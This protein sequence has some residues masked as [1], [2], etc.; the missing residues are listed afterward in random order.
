MSKSFALTILLLFTS[1]AWAEKIYKWVDEN[2]QIHYSAQKPPNQA[3]ETVKIRKGPKLP[4]PA[5][6]APEAADQVPSVEEQLAAQDAQDAADE[7]AAREQLAE[8]DRINRRKQC[9]LARQNL[10][11]LNATVRVTR[12]NA[13]GEIVRMTDDERV[14]AMKTAQQAIRRYCQ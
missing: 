11:A 9:D 12:K 10:A 6:P 13:E 1:L 4:P 2:G 7:A 3:A 5:E 14:N 8:A